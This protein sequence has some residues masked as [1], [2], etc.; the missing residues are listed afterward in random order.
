[1]THLQSGQIE[2]KG[3]I[4]QPSE[5]PRYPLTQVFIIKPAKHKGK[6]CLCQVS[7]CARA[8]FDDD[9]SLSTITQDQYEH[10]AGLVFDIGGA[11]FALTPNAQIWPHALNTPTD[12]MAD[13][14]YLA[15]C[16]LGRPTGS[17]NDFTDG[18][19]FLERFYSV[20]DSAN[21]R[22]GLANTAL[23]RSK[24]N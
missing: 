6:Q 7:K 4:M 18:Q 16:N 17:G 19:V 24:I 9:T 20:Y 8:L 22:A 23:T 10:S 12:G 21:N 14:I 5:P 11:E 13:K 1:M 3:L 15:E 2:V